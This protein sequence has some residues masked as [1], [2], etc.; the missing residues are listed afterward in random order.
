MLTSHFKMMEKKKENGETD[1]SKSGFLAP[2]SA[3]VRPETPV[4]WPMQLKDGMS[5]ALEAE[6]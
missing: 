3:Q 4:A 2:Y 6:I 5:I 1:N